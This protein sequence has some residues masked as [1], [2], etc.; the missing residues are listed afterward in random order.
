MVSMNMGKASTVSA[1]GYNYGLGV[2]LST[3]HV[4]THLYM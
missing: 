2:V 3:V 1:I 4:L